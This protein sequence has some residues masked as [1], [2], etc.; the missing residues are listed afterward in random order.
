[1]LDFGITAQEMMEDYTTRSLKELSPGDEISGEIVVGEFKTIPMGNREVAEFYVVLTDHENRQ[2]WVCEFITPY[3][4]ET[5]NIY[6]ENGGLFYTFMDSLNH[7][8]NNTPRDWQENYSVN[9]TRFRNRVNEYISLV[10]VKAVPAVNPEEKTVHLQV[11]KA[12]IKSR[13]T[14]PSLVSIYDIAQEDPIVLM[15]YTHL[16][17]KGE[18]RTVKNIRFELKSLL[19]DEKITEHA[20]QIALKELRMVNDPG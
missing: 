18:R 5:D 14:T 17:N 8:V 10:R 3:S 2:K 6:G 19:D 20:Y 12:Q 7:V 11:L 15:A 1:M 4:P 9:F 16:R 13:S